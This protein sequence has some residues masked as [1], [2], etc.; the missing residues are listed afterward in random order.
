E[1][2]SWEEALDEI[3]YRVSDV[4]ERWGSQAVLPLNYAGPH[5]LLAY[6][7]MSLRFFHRLR[8]SQLYRR[9]LCGGVRSGA[10]AGAHCAGAGIPP[11]IRGGGEHQLG[12]GYKRGCVERASRALHPPCETEGGTASGRRSAAHEDRRTSR[13]ASADLARHGHAPG[14]G[15][16]GGAGARR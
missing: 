15:D 11:R 6:D 16:R 2:I 10:W 4:V 1:R 14:L 12:L 8:A 7:S 9:A 13:S 3:F 5:G